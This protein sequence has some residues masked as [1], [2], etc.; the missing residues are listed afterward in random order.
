M[1]ILSSQFLKSGIAFLRYGSFIEDVLTDWWKLDFE[2]KT[3]KIWES[4]Q[5]I[6]ILAI[7]R[8]IFYMW[9]HYFYTKSFK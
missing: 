1:A 6:G 3:L 8:S 7:Q 9:K 2:K 4:A 5:S